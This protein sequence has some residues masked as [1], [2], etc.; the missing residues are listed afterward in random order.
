MTDKDGNLV[1]QLHWLGPSER[2]NPSN[3]QCLPTLPPA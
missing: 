3:G 2:E 1:W